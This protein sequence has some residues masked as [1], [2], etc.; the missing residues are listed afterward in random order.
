MTLLAEVDPCVDGLTLEV[1][2]L[3]DVAVLS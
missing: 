3:L 2:V 1:S